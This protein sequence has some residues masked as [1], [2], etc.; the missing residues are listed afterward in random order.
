MGSNPLWMTEW[1]CERLD[2]QPG[3]RVLDLGCGYAKSSIF[4]AREFGVQVW[5][6]DLW[7]PATENWQRI[8]DAK[9]DGPR[10]SVP[11]RRPVAAVRGRILRRDRRGRLLSLFRHRRFVSELSCSIR[12]AGRAD[13]HR[14]GR[15]NR[16]NADAGARAPSA[17]LD[18]GS[19]GNPFGRL[20]AT[21]LGAH[22]AWW[23]S[24]PPTR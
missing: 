11:L 12:E 1:L 3:M 19:L 17:I 14:R 22:R 23:K 4:L 18:A 21:T 5:A 10:F 8:R 7:V 16:R 13:R 15:T 24:N 2:L 20:V 9:L 6:T